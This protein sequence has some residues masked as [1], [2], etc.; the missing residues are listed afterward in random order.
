MFS[1]FDS[2]EDAIAL[3]NATNYALTAS[4]FGANLSRVLRTVEQLRA[5]VVAVN[6]TRMHYI[7][8][9][10]GGTKKFGDRA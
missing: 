3:A 7:G 10:F 1:S 4:V 9:P 6:S 5:G 2:D 8:L